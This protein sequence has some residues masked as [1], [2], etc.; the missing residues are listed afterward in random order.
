MHLMLMVMAI[1]LGG[2]RRNSRDMVGRGKVGNA[3]GALVGV[4][5]RWCGFAP[6]KVGGPTFVVN[7][8]GV[9]D[10]RRAAFLELVA[11]AAAFARVGASPPP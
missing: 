6:L 10:W 4:L 2:V 3:G 7:F 1:R 9:D 8:S 11:D 5:L